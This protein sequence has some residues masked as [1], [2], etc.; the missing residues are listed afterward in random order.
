MIE[1]IKEGEEK[2][3]GEVLQIN[4]ELGNRHYEKL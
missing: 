1:E 2:N 3:G 4:L